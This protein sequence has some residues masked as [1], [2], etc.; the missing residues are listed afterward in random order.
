MHNDLSFGHIFVILILLIIVEIVFAYRLYQGL[1]NI[2]EKYRTT[3]PYTAWFTLIPVAGIAFYWILLPHRIPESFRNY[4]SE[5]PGSGKE[6]KDYGKAMGLG[7][8]ISTTC[9]LIPVVNVIAWIPAVIFLVVFLVQFTEMEKQLSRKNANAPIAYQADRPNPGG[10]G[11]A[12]RAPRSAEASHDKFTQLER[13]KQLL[14]KDVLTAD[15][16]QEEK[17]KLLQEQQ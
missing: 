9:L 14:D 5:N 12:P 3:E 10:H 13:L 4:F 2:P 17:R 8:A 16:Y 7:T 15:E 1:Q 11:A 6:P